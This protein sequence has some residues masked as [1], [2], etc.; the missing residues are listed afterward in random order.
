MNKKLINEANIELYS[1]F[2]NVRGVFYG[3]L[4]KLANKDYIINNNSKDIF[5]RLNNLENLLKKM[6]ECLN[7]FN[8]NQDKTN[9][10][11]DKY[12]WSIIYSNQTNIKRNY[13]LVYIDIL[14]NNLLIKLINS[15]YLYRKEI[16]SNK[17][18][19]IQHK[20]N[21]N[22]NITQH[23]DEEDIQNYIIQNKFKLISFKIVNQDKVENN[24]PIIAYFEFGLNNFTIK[25][26]PQKP[27]NVVTQSFTLECRYKSLYNTLLFRKIHNELSKVI[28]FLYNRFINRE[29]NGMNFIK[30]FINHIQDLDKIFSIKCYGCKKN[31]RYSNVE[32]SFFPPFFKYNIDIYYYKFKYPIID[33]DKLFFHPECID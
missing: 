8:E 32:K 28:E 11:S 31:S 16:F 19:L 21:N 26:I 13:S 3:L 22:Q 17:A 7:Y 15:D 14:I 10:I 18:N 23:I 27:N 6:N 30:S 33:K 1:L 12:I 24:H 2:K 29:N 4:N 5:D 25:L 20:P 9:S